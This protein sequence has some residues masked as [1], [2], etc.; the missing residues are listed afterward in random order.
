MTPAQADTPRIRSVPPPAAGPSLFELAS[1]LDGGEAQRVLDE[2]DASSASPELRLMRCRAL[3]ATGASAAARDELSTLGATPL[4]EPELRGALARLLIDLGDPAT[5]LEQA[6]RACA[7]DP[8]ATGARIALA[9]ALVRLERRT[10]DAALLT[11][12]RDA[13]AELGAPGNRY[14]A[15][16]LALR[17]CIQA[18]IG[19]SDK[20]IAIAQ[21]AIGLDADSVDATAALALSAARLGQFRDAQQAWCRVLD[22]DHQEADALSDTLV[23]LGVDL[24][25]ALPGPA[26]SIATA[27]P[28]WHA[29]ELRLSEGNASGLAELEQHAQRH[30]ER[31]TANQR[32]SLQVLATLS[33]GY[34]NTAPCFRNFA[35][36]DISLRSIRQLEAA[37][38]ASY[39]HQPRPDLH[40]DYW[41]LT[42]TLGSYVGE[43]LRQVHAGRWTGS[44]EDAV[45]ARVLARAGT[46]EPLRQIQARLLSGSSHDLTLA[47]RSAFPLE[48]SKEWDHRVPIAV[49][50]ATP[51]A[52][53]WPSATEAP[54]LGAALKA[55][56]I[57][58]YLERLG[59][60]ALDGSYADF[61]RLDRYLD[62]LAPA[63]A[64]SVG[65]DATRRACGLLGCH[66][67]EIV[68]AEFGGQWVDQGLA[69]SA[70]S[71]DGPR[72]TAL[73]L[74]DGRKLEPLSILAER[75][76]PDRK[77]SLQ[78]W[79]QTLS[80]AR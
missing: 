51:W 71:T 66:V 48:N 26:A 34:L 47:L 3:I 35:P 15:L 56:V 69:L 14:A 75:L 77:F 46:W 7:D 27:Q 5:A 73:V 50:P 12:A 59:V 43:V 62:L 24:Q 1:W 8:M 44:L 55:S 32:T 70:D 40:T 49:L 58:S 10:G 28:V 6:S 22:L 4:L 17:A 61:S 63:H 68:R 54:S 30:I 20:A 36:F 72:R 13:L 25:Q 41:S 60:G 38:L 74:G 2:V 18:S 23:A 57:S 64:P 53:A 52:R 79:H 76:G 65:D 16:V 45:H 37:L 67:G 42:L 29:V 19:E 80:F 33:A 9:W 11:R 21:R 39:G 31:V 78:E